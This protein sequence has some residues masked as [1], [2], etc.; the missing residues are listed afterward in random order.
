MAVQRDHGVVPVGIALLGDTRM[1][2]DIGDYREPPRLAN[3]P[4]IAEVS[5]IKTDDPGI[6]AVGIEF[7]VEDVV[8]NPAPV[9]GGIA[10]QERPALARGRA[11]SAPEIVAKTLPKPP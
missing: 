5:A 4:E 9:S 7:V 3:G 6:E 1:N 10:Q 11:T 2:M 8:H